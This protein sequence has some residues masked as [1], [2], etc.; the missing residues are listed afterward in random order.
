[1]TQ[2]SARI[3]AHGVPISSEHDPFG[4]IPRVSVL[5]TCSSAL[6]LLDS[7]FDGVALRK[8]IGAEP[9]RTLPTHPGDTFHG[10]VTRP[11]GS[12]GRHRRTAFASD[13]KP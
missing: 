7:H 13:A 9:A 12:H 1:M 10:A 8:R 6:V 4:C 2:L 5:L 3:R 11:N